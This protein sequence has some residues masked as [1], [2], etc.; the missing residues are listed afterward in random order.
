MALRRRKGDV[1][2]SAEDAEANQVQVDVELDEVKSNG[3]TKKKKRR[4]PKEE[5]ERKFDHLG[6][7]VGPDGWFVD[8]AQLPIQ[9]RNEK[10]YVTPKKIYRR[11]IEL[12]VNSNCDRPFRR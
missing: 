12:A 3:S 7:E 10:M 8:P 1:S 11:L 5:V 6:R 2:S 4:S 9:K